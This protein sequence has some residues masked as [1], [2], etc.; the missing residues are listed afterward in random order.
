MKGNESHV[1]DLDQAL[2][3]VGGDRELYRELLDMLF[4]DASEQVRDMREAIG[5]G[6]AQRVERVAHSL[7]GAAASL[8]AGP[9]R[10]AAL[11]LEMLGRE[12]TL[13]GAAE[14]LA[15]LEAELERLRHFAEALK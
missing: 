15:E 14:A 11:W 13:A 12:V 3:R 10:D 9:V 4:E 5:R 7:K 8:E 2:D 1:V 6:D